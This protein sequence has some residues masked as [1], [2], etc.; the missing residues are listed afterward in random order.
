MFGNPVSR[1]NKNEDDFKN[2]VDLKNE[3]DFNKHKIYA[4]VRKIKKSQVV[5]GIF[6]RQ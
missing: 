6:G 1:E 3:E 5:F 2:E 4:K